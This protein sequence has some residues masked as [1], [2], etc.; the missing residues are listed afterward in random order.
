MNLIGY[1][2][3]LQ[4]NIL[5]FITVIFC[6][7]ILVSAIIRLI[8]VWYSNK[9]A[10]LSAADLGGKIYLTALN[11]SYIEH[12]ETNSSEIL[13]AISSKVNVVIYSIIIPIFTLLSSTIILI[14]IIALLSA[15]NFNVTAG[16]FL[17]FAIIYVLIGI[18]TK[19]K[20]DSCGATI[21]KEY[22]RIVQN[23]NEGL[24]GIRDILLDGTQN[25]YYN[26]FSKLDNS[27]RSAQAKIHFIAA[28][29]RFILEATGMLAIT[30]FAY[31]LS[32]RSL[33]GF[34]EIIP[35]L[36]VLAIS[37]QR[38]L[39]LLQQIYSSW[40]SIR[41][42]GEA[43]SDILP[44]LKKHLQM[45][46][47]EK[48]CK[49]VF[50]EIS[51]QNIDFSY[52]NNG[53]PVLSNINLKIKKGER[54][55]IIGASGGGKSTLLDLIMCLL[56]PNRGFIKID[57]KPIDKASTSNWQK[58]I[59]HVPQNIYLSD[60]SIE[61]NI[62]FGINVENIDRKWVREVAKMA[63][64][65]DTI[66][67]W[68]LSYD[69]LIGENGI[70]LSGGQRQRIGIARALY[71]NPSLL[72]L[73]EATSALDPDTESSVLESIELLSRELTIL[74]ASHRLSTL[75][76]CNVVYKISNSKIIQVS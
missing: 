23:V 45:K 37:A 12:T 8:L 24:G 67:S 54:V 74:I 64:I 55:G 3:L 65:A 33:N 2:G 57:G 75:N 15:I 41:S 32:I 14:A 51:L 62:A 71:K 9:V 1:L 13:S 69:T 22:S 66:E 70:R 18:V 48:N 35:V 73:D 17:F 20:L 31:F 28:C 43:L 76:D 34:I 56:E 30:I 47:D 26:D 72:I 59:S 61:K 38:M 27:L 16:S 46:S 49:L 58:N 36:G 39:P 25:I 7:S 29:P 5:L 21:A 50:E 42:G 53:M 11:Q 60:A 19:S 44:M 6:F 52:S 4:E 40:A 63:K 10:F 68:P